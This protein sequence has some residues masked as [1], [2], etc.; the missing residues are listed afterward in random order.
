MSMNPR[1]AAI[2]AIA[3]TTHK[4]QHID[5]KGGHIKDVFAEAI[6][7]VRLARVQKAALTEVIKRRPEF[8]MKLFSSFSERLRQSDGSMP[9]LVLGRSALLHRVPPLRT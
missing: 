5:F 3:T 2:Q 4:L 7:D 6:T 9:Q 1:Q 8:S